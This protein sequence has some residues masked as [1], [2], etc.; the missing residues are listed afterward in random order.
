MEAILL[1][2]LCGEGVHNCQVVKAEVAQHRE[3]V[4]KRVEA[5]A[6]GA[7]D[8]AAGIA[9][10]YLDIGMVLMDLCKQAVKVVDGLDILLLIARFLHVVL[11]DYQ[12]AVTDSQVAVGG[13]TVELAVQLACVYKALAHRFNNALAVLLDKV[14][15]VGHLVR[16]IVG[17]EAVGADNEA[18]QL[19]GACQHK[20]H[21]LLVVAH[22]D[23]HKLNGIV[24][25]LLGY[26]VNLGLNELI[27]LGHA[28]NKR[29]G[30]HKVHGLVTGGLL[31][32]GAL[33]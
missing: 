27:V 29:I 18:V 15:K 33:R 28:V 6:K 10:D 5:H 32:T 8:G 26:L 12:A 19:L 31:F 30:H 4:C 3:A 21:L 23:R 14:G 24:E 13:D 1:I 11:A 17:V 20:L 16:R 7:V 22:G 9:G 2:F 25:L